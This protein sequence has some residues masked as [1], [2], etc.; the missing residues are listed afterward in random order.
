VRIKSLILFFFL[1]LIVLSVWA[2]QTPQWKGKIEYE[3]KIKVVKNPQE[4][5]FGEIVLELE[6]ELAI[7]NDT[8]D[9]LMF[10]RWI[11]VDIDLDGKLFV[12]DRG[13]FRIQVF[14][15]KGNY[16]QTIGKKGEGPGELADPKSLR[17]DENGN[18]FIKD[19]VMIHHFEKNGQYIKSYPVPLNCNQF[20]VL[21]EENIIG[22]KPK[23]DPKN[24]SDE[25]VLLDG[26]GMVLKTLAN[27]PSLKM[28]S[29]FLRKDRFTIHD[30]KLY[31]CPYFN[32][33][34]VYGF[35]KDYKLIF[36]DSKGE[37]FKR[38]ERDEPLKKITNRDKSRIVDKLIVTLKR[39]NPEK[40]E[41]K[42]DLQKKV[43]I[44]SSLP[45]FDGI[46]CDEDGNIYIRREKFDLSEEKGTW[47]DFFD[48]EGRYL[49]KLK[50]EVRVTRIK[51]E[52]IYSTGLDRE[53]GYFQVKR[54][55]IKNWA[56]AK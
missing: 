55:K 25:V 23:I 45:F 18:I 44:P 16:L 10:F 46:F 17:L 3:D 53:T 51:K 39:Q 54:Y 49:Y 26:K 31:L 33:T 12:L 1:A 42:R 48:K 36:V 47:F 11:D 37:I 29:W 35:S 2:K 56:P 20:K 50:I 32:D 27:Y 41:S 19:N 24:L 43:T 22:D 6:E 13:N 34:A 15:K 9:N 4:P 38:I 5:L 40:K 21:S 52:Y 8:D 30:P 28:E 7:G 14:D